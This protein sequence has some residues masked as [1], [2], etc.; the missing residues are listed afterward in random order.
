[1][2][3]PSVISVAECYGVSH[4]T[5]YSMLMYQVASQKMENKER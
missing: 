3:D 1:M 5:L 2:R 4:T